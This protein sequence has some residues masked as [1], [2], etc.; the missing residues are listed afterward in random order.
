MPF[1]DKILKYGSLSI[2]GMEKNT[3]KT[4]CLNYVLGHLP[5]SLKKTVT[6]IGIDG[7]RIDQVT[8]TAKPEIHL[9]ENTYFAT[10]ETHYRQRRLVSEI[11]DISDFSTSLGRIV[12]ARTVYPGKALIS[13]PSS[14]FELERWMKRIAPLD[15]GLTIIDG[16]ISRL[17]SAS[18]AVSESLILTTGAALSANIPT[19]VAKTAFVVERIGLPLCRQELRD[20]FRPLGQGIWTYSDGQTGRL[21]VKSSFLLDELDSAALKDVEAI[22]LTGALTDR[23]LKKLRT[24]DPVPLLVVRDF[25]K[26]FVDRNEYAAY[27]RAGGRIEVLDRSELIAL[28]VNPTSPSGYRLDSEKLS[29]AIEAATGYPAYDLRKC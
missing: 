23:F 25:T 27:F 29:E 19:L 2:V 14:A 8:T 13:G 15:S 5:V 10:S 11:C 3:G 28:C 4:E 26:F 1:I 20:V 18:P 17:S 7:E 21:E 6:S 9:G 22:Y 12:T 24:L 16:A